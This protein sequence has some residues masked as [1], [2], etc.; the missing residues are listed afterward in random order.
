[1]YSYKLYG[2]SLLNQYAMKG[3]ESCYGA[4]YGYD[5]THGYKAG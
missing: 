2:I 1:M 3:Q 5:A 4:I